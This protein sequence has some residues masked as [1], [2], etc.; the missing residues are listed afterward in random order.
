MID[1]SLL[2]GLDKSWPFWLVTLMLVVGAAIDGYKLKVPNWLTFPFVFSGWIISTVSFGW[3]GL[4]WSLV[5]TAVGIACLY[6]LYSIGGMGAG[7]VK[8]LAGVGAW[9][10]GTITFY[11]FCVT[12]IVGGVLSVLMV[13][14]S[15]EW[16]K[17]YYQMLGIW[18]EI[19]TV[20]DPDKLSEIAAERKSRMRLLPYGIPIAIGTIMYF[21]YSGM[22]Q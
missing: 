13:V 7:D 9:V 3:E 5:G 15:G 12:A 10:G 6:P 14:V 21:A 22:L 11:S 2:D 1:P 20:R 8:L 16:K 18:N 4:A 17:H 19:I